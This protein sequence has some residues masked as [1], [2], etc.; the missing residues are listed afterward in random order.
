MCNTAR[1]ERIQ[2]GTMLALLMFAAQ[3]L[4]TILINQY[5]HMVYRISLQLKA[6][7]VQMLYRKSLRITSAVKSDKGVGTI[8]NLQSNDA[9]KLWSLPNYLHI[10]WSG[11]FQILAVMALLVRVLG[12]I[13]AF[14][15]LIVTVLL[16]PLNA[17]AGKYMAGFRKKKMSLTDSRVKLTSEVV[18]G[19]EILLRI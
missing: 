4:Q 11:P 17:V 13:P 15:G 18:N 8:A 16:I 19:E 10:I 3:A 14:A 9:N 2:T 5:F 7:L 6:Q 12:F 1:K